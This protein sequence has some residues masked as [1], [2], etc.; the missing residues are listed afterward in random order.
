MK[1]NRE[2]RKYKVLENTLFQVF[3]IITYV[4]YPSVSTTIFSAFVC[5]DFDDGSSYMRADYST[6]CDSAEYAS[7]YGLAVF[8]I[9]VYPIGIPAMYFVML[10][11]SEE[12]LDPQKFFTDMNLMEAVF[13]RRK[14]A[15]HLK[16]LY[17]PYA[18]EYWWTEVMECLRKLLLTGFV[19]FMYSGSAAQIIFGLTI[20]IFFGVLY[21]YIQPY[22]MPSNNTFAAYVNFVLAF[23]LMLSF[24]LRFESILSDSEADDLLID[25]EAISMTLMLSSLSVIVLFL[26]M[27]SFSFVSSSED[28]FYDMDFDDERED[29]KERRN[30]R[31]SFASS[32]EPSGEKKD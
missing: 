12:N 31:L 1:F 29:L 30:E 22:L 17:D 32:I 9:F 7:I 16:F 21:C 5:E 11:R 26:V 4:I 23:T 28:I 6:S 15:N 18:P 14:E 27:V 2:S 20:S 25:P 13:H 3:I 10:L 24:A 19:V 8:M